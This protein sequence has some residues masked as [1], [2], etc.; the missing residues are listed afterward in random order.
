MGNSRFQSFLSQWLSELLE[1][2]AHDTF[3][4]SKNTINDHSVPFVLVNESPQAWVIKPRELIRLHFKT[5]FKI[6]EKAVS[7][8]FRLTR[9]LF[10]SVM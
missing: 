8:P 4:W 6:N 3:Y 9:L 5:L 2:R 1:H 10:P 7:I